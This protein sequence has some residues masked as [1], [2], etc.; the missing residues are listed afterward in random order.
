MLCITDYVFQQLM[1][2]VE[3]V[4]E[5]SCGFLF[6]KVENGSTK[7]C[8]IMPV[9][10]VS[11]YYKEVRFQIDAKDFVKAE[12]LA[13]S[14]NF[15]LTGVYHT[16]LIDSANPS[17]TDRVS[18]LPNFFYLIISLPNQKFSEMKFWKLNNNNQLEEE[19]FT[20]LN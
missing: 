9:P 8:K 6:G 2:K 12:K 11:P 3:R 18:A 19:V 16:H 1:L 7:I 5:E 4:P 14:N 17:E 15:E 13:D 20:L 10:N